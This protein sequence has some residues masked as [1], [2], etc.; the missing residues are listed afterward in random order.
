MQSPGPG[1][2]LICLKNSKEASGAKAVR[3]RGAEGGARE[4]TRLGRDHVAP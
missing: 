4:E 3:R 1:A 2:G